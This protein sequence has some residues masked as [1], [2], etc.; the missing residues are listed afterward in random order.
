MIVLTWAIS[1]E[2]I[3]CEIPLVVYCRLLYSH[4]TIATFHHDYTLSRSIHYTVFTD[5]R[6]LLKLIPRKRTTGRTLFE[7]LYALYYCS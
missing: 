2:F 5:Y 6:Q 3:L 4:S 7:Y 1:N